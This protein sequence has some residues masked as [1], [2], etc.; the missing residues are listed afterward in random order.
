L[1]QH[2]KKNAPSCVTN[3]GVVDENDLENRF[4]QLKIQAVPKVAYKGRVVICYRPKH[5]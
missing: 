4:A 1:S 5:R 2:E 3:G